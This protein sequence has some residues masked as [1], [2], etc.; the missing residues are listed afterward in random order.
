M[1]AL[2][3]FD[4]PEARILN[5]LASVLNAHHYALNRQIPRLSEVQESLLGRVRPLN[6]LV[7][8]GSLAPGEVNHDQIAHIGGWY[9]KGRIQGTLVTAGWGQHIGFPGLLWGLGEREEIPVQV[10]HAATM[11]SHWEA[12]DAFEGEAY[13]RIVIPYL[14]DDGTWGLGCVYQVNPDVQ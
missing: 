7:I 3:P 13:Q 1:S 8:Y 9:A 11:T 10:L 14:L 2:S 4:G 6:R 5:E 12:L